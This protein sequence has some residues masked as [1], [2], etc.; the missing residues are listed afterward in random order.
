MSIKRTFNGATIIRPG[1]YSAVKVQNLTGFPLQAT[2]I[3]GIIGEAVGGEPRV[4]DTL[5][6]PQIQSAKDR[7]KSGPIADALAL[8][9][10]PSKDPRVVNGA[11]T[12]VIYKV[13]ASLQSALELSSN[14]SQVI[15][16]LASKNWGGDE[17][18]LKA[19]IETG[20][21]V[22]ADAK[23]EGT[24]DGP[25]DLSGG[26]DTLI[27]TV[28]GTVYTYTST[29]TG[30]AET[31]AAVMGDLN[32]ANWSPSKP[33]VASLSGSKVDLTIDTGA[34]LDS[35]LDYGYISIDASSTLDTIVGLAG[36][37]RGVKGSRIITIANDQ[38]EES[39]EVGGQSVISVKYTGT[40]VTCKLTIGDSLG[41]R[42]LTTTCAG[43]AAD[44]L[45]LT[46]GVTENGEL[47]PKMT[48][49]ALVDQ[50]NSHA[51]YDAAV[52]YSDPN[53]NAIEIDYYSLLHIGDVTVDLK[54]DVEALVEWSTNLSQ[55]AQA[56]RKS[57]IIGAVALIADQ[58]F[59]GGADGAS[60]NTDW[61]TGF[62][63][64]KLVR[65]NS[66]IPLISDD[67]GALSIDS[68]NALCA[69]H[70]IAMTST[71]G[72]SERAAFC[73]KLGTK[74]E[75]MAAAKAL[76]SGL[77]HLVGQD[78]QVS[79][80]SNNDEL[81][82]LD[83]WA[84]ACLCA[85]MRA[86]SDVGEP[87]TFKL[88]NAN[89]IRVRDGSWD[90][91]LDYA[92]LLDAGCT[93]CEPLDSA[94]FRIVLDNTTYGVDPNFVWNR[95][96]VVEAGYYV[97]YDLRFNLEALFT[98]TKART[99]SADAIANLVKARMEIYLDEDIIVG[100]D[101]NEGVGYKNLSV[102]IEGSTALIDIIITP[103][104]GIDFILPTIYLADIRQTAA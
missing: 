70:V 57:N 7:Y 41:S 54:R 12:V 2:G 33:I 92:E 61:G 79:S 19:T 78:V 95:G 99:G 3:V 31:P 40:A 62:D 55:L 65:L 21:V 1:A 91:K 27:L 102:V 45:D 22:D 58:F 4:L 44:D 53:L 76:N 52:T 17:N 24:I 77:V 9:A 36:S 63:A 101:L 23:I 28:N 85:G 93:I 75:F 89:D 82:Y 71:L 15:V 97:A 46:L 11:S 25:F 38:D 18:Q 88:I 32:G 90:P 66:V 51:K 14:L 104:Q 43:V 6:G 13:N 80:H 94:G 20:T 64:L 42:K 96:S 56:T 16:D 37:N 73:S 87:I 8:L 100:D 26:S 10:E 50:I 69:S 34:I 39:A 48:I 81:T 74:A 49:T 84:F 103:V 83:P 86:G 72:K 47:K 59:T 30:A 35:D 5:T 29:L 98:G 68:I 67:V 60:A